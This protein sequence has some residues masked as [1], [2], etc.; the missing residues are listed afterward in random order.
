MGHFLP[1]APAAKAASLFAVGHV[2]SVTDLP[3]GA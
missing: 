3:V 2:K 1:H